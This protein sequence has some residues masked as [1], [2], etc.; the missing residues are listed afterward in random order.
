MDNQTQSVF[1]MAVYS[2]CSTRMACAATAAIKPA[3]AT[4]I[5]VPNGNTEAGYIQEI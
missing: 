1:T 5:V 4:F 2:V 3:I